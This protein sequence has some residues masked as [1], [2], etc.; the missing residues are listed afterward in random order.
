MPRVQNVSSV[1][2][3]IELARRSVRNRSV[4]VTSPVLTLWMSWQ[5][6]RLCMLKA[7]IRVP[8]ASPTCGSSLHVHWGGEHAISRHL[9]GRP[10]TPG[11]LPVRS[12]AAKHATDRL[13]HLL[14]FSW[15][16][17]DLLTL[18][19]FNPVDKR[20]SLEAYCHHSP[21]G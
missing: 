6:S 1:K 3:R 12:P 9:S 11:H 17:H 13:M 2:L 19:I 5:H 14:V 8:E 16:Y 4:L 21:Q 18:L 10:S 20:A 7:H 15:P